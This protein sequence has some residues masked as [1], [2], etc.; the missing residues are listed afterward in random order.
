M[1]NS[2]KN[3]DPSDP[4]K[5]HKVDNPDDALAYW[6]PRKKRRAKATNMPD[7]DNPG[8]EEQPPQH[9]PRTQQNS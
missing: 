6:T 3:S 8:Q 5:K 2:E 1:K 4:I 7:V 9:P